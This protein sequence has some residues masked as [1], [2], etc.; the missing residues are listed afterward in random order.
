MYKLSK[1]QIAN[2]MIL[3]ELFYRTVCAKQYQHYYDIGAENTTAILRSR[4][5]NKTVFVKIR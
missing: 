4:K 5:P 2:D 3:S 1:I